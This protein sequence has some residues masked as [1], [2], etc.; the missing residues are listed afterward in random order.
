MKKS[1][2]GHVQTVIRLGWSHLA[3]VASGLGTVLAVIWIAFM[4]ELEDM[5]AFVAWQRGQIHSVSAA[6]PFV[7]PVSSRTLA[8]P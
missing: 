5:T 4:P 6:G 2:E 8:C 1:D 7:V 3:I